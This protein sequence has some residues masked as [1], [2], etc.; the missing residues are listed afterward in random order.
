[1]T[2]WRKRKNGRRR[3]NNKKK[4]N[5]REEDGG[6]LMK[7]EISLTLGIVKEEETSPLLGNK[8][9]PLFHKLLNRYIH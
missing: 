3:L 8:K 1:M 4:E 5:R 9:T 6:G 2:I 7:E